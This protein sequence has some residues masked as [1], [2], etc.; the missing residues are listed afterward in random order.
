MSYLDAYKARVKASGASMQDAVLQTTKRQAYK[1]I[2][3]SPTLSYVRL[4]DNADMIP[5][6]VS[7]KDTF[8]K[9]EYLFVPDTA[10]NV[11][12]YIRQDD[13][14]YLAVDQKKNEIYPQ[15]IGELC[16]ETFTLELGD[17]IKVITGYD[18]N[19]RPI[20]EFIS[21]TETLPCVMTTKIPSTIENSAIPLPDGAMIVRIPFIEDKLPKVNYIFT[22]RDQ[23]FKVTTIS[24]E[25][26]VDN[27]G[28]IEMRLQK[29]T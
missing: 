23:Q 24:Y 13:A 9:R 3:D 8:H 17:P 19:K 28:F 26:V 11:G 10:V 15:L 7:D 2:M 29:E 16:N 12:D 20:Y 18:D 5:S 14:I 22:H 1:Y 25:H 4:N 21:S 6:I 27:V